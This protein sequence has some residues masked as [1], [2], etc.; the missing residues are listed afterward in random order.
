M[1]RPEG[2]DDDGA[3]DMTREQAEQKARALGNHAL[4]LFWAT[5]GKSAMAAAVAGVLA[6]VGYIVTTVWEPAEEAVWSYVGERIGMIAM[7]AEIQSLADRLTALEPKEPIALYDPNLSYIEGDACSRGAECVARFRVQRT[8]RGTA[9]DAPALVPVVR[10]HGGVEHVAEVLGVTAERDG[11][12]IDTGE[13]G[14]GV[15]ADTDWT[16]VTVRFRVPMGTKVGRGVYLSRL[17]YTCDGIRLAP[18]E[19][20][21]LPFRI[22][23]ARPD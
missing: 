21:P 18:V 19:T 9:C 10:N 5:L 20:I 11:E 17:L 8:D 4:A 7:A 1:T 15:K 13:G 2:A 12:V 6:G 14:S 16:L 23:A 3:A 22:L